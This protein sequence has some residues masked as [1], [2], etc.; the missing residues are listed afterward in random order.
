[1]GIELLVI[2]GVAAYVYINGYVQAYRAGSLSRNLRRTTTGTALYIIEMIGAA[3]LIFGHKPGIYIAASAMVVNTCY[4]ITGAWLL[5]MG[6]F[7]SP[8]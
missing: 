1:V 5:V 7:K 4:M 2:A 6:V 8:K 3:L